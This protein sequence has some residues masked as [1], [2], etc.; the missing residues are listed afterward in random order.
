[1]LCCFLSICRFIKEGSTVTV[2][3]VIQKKTDNVLMI[4]PP[5]DLISTGCQW[6]KLFFPTNLF[7]IIL[8][9]QDSL[10]DD[11]VPV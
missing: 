5:S 1:M 7:G 3:G 11:V 9:C 4:V 2:M 8:I 6:G 10:K